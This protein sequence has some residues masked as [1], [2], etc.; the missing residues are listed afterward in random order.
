M[1]SERP[2]AGDGL[3]ATNHHKLP[4]SGMVKTLTMLPRL[5]IAKPLLSDFCEHTL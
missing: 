5:F 3:L 2:G 1:V 4:I